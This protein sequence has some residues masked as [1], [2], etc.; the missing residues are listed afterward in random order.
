MT[1]T[2]CHTPSLNSNICSITEPPPNRLSA[3]A[4]L[5]LPLLLWPLHTRPILRLAT[6]LLGVQ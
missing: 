3:P 4:N 1:H 5:R 6:P 2:H